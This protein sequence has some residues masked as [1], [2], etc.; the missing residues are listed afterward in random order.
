MSAPFAALLLLAAATVAA[1]PAEEPASLKTLS[2]TIEG[3]LLVPEHRGRIPVVL[4]IAGSGPTDRN[5]NSAGLPGANN[6]LKM[7]AEGLA[8]NGIASLRY[9]KRGIAASGPAG[10]SESELRFDMYVDD[11]AAWA[12]QLKNDAR[13]S[14]VTI[15]G[16][17]EG[18]LIGMVASR[19]SNANGFVSIAGIAH[20]ADVTLREQLG[21]Q[22]PPELMKESDRVLD[23][24][25]A[26]KT[27]SDPPPALAAIYRPSV[28][29]YM[30]SWLRYDPSAEIAKLTI[31]V[32]IVQGT[33]D[34]QV[35]VADA[36]ALAAAAKKPKLVLV[37]GMN[38]ILKQ[39]GGELKEQVG[40]YSDP[41]LAVV[42]QAIDAV[43]AY[44]KSRR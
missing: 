31:P 44:V 34:I 23:A 43:V 32:L 30:I 27:V 25:K 5:G 14:G 12:A 3:T 8:A 11:A 42:P 35:T 39:V 9:D 28:Q 7:L 15:V 19:K 33:T 22:L 38:H 26:G 37:D 21:K 24:L 29:P 10:K 13:F 6:S 17:S 18:S 2:G 36:K 4:L 41:S 40:A 20:S 1:A 16:H